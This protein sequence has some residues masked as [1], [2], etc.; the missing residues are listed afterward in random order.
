[1]C[2]YPF[3]KKQ[4]LIYLRAPRHGLDDGRRVPHRKRTW[5]DERLHASSSATI[6]SDQRSRCQARACRISVRERSVELIQL[7]VTRK[8]M[9]DRPQ[10]H[11]TCII[12]GH[13]VDVGWPIESLLCRGPALARRDV[14][15]QALVESPY[16]VFDLCWRI[17]LPHQIFRFFS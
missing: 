5:L 4:F 16:S 11:R 7:V 13:A 12:C 6:C 17:R 10:L 15:G 2:V 3:K 14:P 8:R 9:L 1:M